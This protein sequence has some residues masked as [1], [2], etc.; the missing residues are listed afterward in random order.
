MSKLRTWGDAMGL[1][2]APPE[3]THAER[4]RDQ[5]RRD[6]DNAFAVGKAQYREYLSD[7][8]RAGA[9]A[10]VP[11]REST[12]P[13]VG[14][15][16]CGPVD[17]FY[18]LL[19]MGLVLGGIV[20]VPLA[21]VLLKHPPTFQPSQPQ[22]TENLGS[23]SGTLVAAGWN[24]HKYVVTPIDTR[25]YPDG[26][27]LNLEISVG[28]GVAAASFDLFPWGARLPTE[29][30]PNQQGSLA[31]AWNVPRGGTAQITYRFQRGDLFQFGAEG[32]WPSPVG[33]GNSYT[34]RASVSR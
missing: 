24:K 13:D 14:D 5:M 34:V 8:A 26:G 16:N 33:A 27:V 7:Q 6:R 17:I 18:L 30:M 22:L 19:M 9:R 10:R 28:T 21:S 32:N 31:S 20:G 12:G 23:W 1:Y 4:I 11:G 25:R 15:G 29:G 2:D 3:P